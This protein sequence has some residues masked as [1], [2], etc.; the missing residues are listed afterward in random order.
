MADSTADGA[1]ARNVVVVDGRSIKVTHPDKVMYPADNLTK[2]A[3]IA[4]YVRMAERLLPLLAGRPVT[5]IRW[6]HGVGGSRFFEKQLP[7]G[8]P[9][10][11]QTLTLDHSEGAVTYP[12][13]T[14]AATLAWLGQLNALEL[15]APQWRWTGEAP[16]V[17]RLVLDLDPGPGTGLAQC[18]EVAQWLR[19]RLDDDGFTS[20]PVT[21]GS[22]GLHLYAGWDPDQR[23]GSTSEY[24]KAL[25]TAASSQFPRLVTAQMKRE[26]RAGRV[27]I[28]WSQNNP[29][30]TTITPYSLR[31]REHPYVAA[32][33]LWAELD[34]VGAKHLT[35]AEV[36][37]RL[38]APDP[39]AALP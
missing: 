36:L 27:F 8:A 37:A 28:D 3:V 23:T 26:V 5:R 15:H 22:K 39:M 7:A 4:Y 33:R 34:D 24:A 25:A 32:P 10:W 1:K 30:K 13:V 18:V 20:V 35:M 29:N 11:V 2:V 19:G 17:D 9:A 6:P 31:G 16:R 12:L 21:S 14:D 38:D